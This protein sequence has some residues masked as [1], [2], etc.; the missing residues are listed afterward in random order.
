MTTIPAQPDTFRREDDAQGL[1]GNALF[2]G[3]III[4]DLGSHPRFGII[5][6]P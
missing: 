2:E 1:L 6:N 3:S 4:L 5:D